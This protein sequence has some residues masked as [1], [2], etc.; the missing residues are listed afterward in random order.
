[1]RKRALFFSHTIQLNFLPGVV[2]STNFRLPL[3][4]KLNLCLSFR[5][6]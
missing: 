1:L 6:Q 3:L 4:L 2:I 5:R